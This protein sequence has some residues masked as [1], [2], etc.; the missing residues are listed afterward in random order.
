MGMPKLH[1]R[2]IFYLSLEDFQKVKAVGFLRGDGDTY[3][4]SAR[5]LMNLGIKNYDPKL[6]E[7]EE[8]RRFKRRLDFLISTE[9]FDK[10]KHIAQSR[11][12]GNKY[13]K[14]SRYLVH[15]GIET[16]LKTLNDKERADFDFIM[17]RVSIIEKD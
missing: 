9:E 12:D 4:P 3:G 8:G 10:I 16:Y 2:M 15:I 17:G 7:G 14:V 13:S 5:I 6:D 11:G 1:R